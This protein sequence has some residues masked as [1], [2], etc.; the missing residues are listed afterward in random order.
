MY[1]FIDRPF[2][3]ER[4]QERKM[5]W[6][7]PLFPGWKHYPEALCFGP[8]DY[9]CCCWRGLYHRRW[10][11]LNPSLAYSFGEIYEGWKDRH[12]HVYSWIDLSHPALHSIYCDVLSE[13][14]IK[15]APSKD[16]IV[17][18]AS[19][20]YKKRKK[21]KTE[22]LSCCF[23]WVD[24]EPVANMPVFFSSLL[25]SSWTLLWPFPSKGKLK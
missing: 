8:R 7:E 25:M 22:T 5:C 11:T 24:V 4:K 17:H 19:W 18:I 3:A 9:S 10:W 16:V 6:P 23:V 20:S 2:E 14:N 21:E 12:I 1:L 13:R 15:E